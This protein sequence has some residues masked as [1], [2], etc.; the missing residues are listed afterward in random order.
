MHVCLGLRH[1][2]QFALM[3]CQGQRLLDPAGQAPTVSDVCLLKVVL[4]LH[5]ELT[6][7]SKISRKEPG[8]WPRRQGCTGEGWEL[9]DSRNPE[10]F[11]P[12]EL[13]KLC[14]FFCNK[15]HLRS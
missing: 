5:P 1:P 15:N 11:G 4:G 6:A 14:S 8:K 7:G 2:W 13:H 10:I 9:E 3:L 12:N